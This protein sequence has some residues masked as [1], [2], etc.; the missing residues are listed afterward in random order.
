M[1][2]PP[3]T[4]PSLP[5]AVVQRLATHGWLDSIWPAVVLTALFLLA[6]VVMARTALRRR[7]PWWLG[8][9]I[10]AVIVTALLAGLAYVNAFAGYVPD[11]TAAARMA[12]FGGGRAPGLGTV[13]RYLLAAPAQRIPGCAV[14]VYLPPGYE[15]PRNTARYPVVYLLPG[16]PGRSVDW[17]SAGRIDTTMDLLIGQHSMPAAIVVAPD[18]NGGSPTRDTEGL[19]VYQ[20]PQ[21]QTYLAATV[22]AWVDRT[23]RTIPEPGA[24]IIGGMSAGGY[25]A[26]NLGLKYE[27]V[28]GG[29]IAQEPY[30][31]PGRSALPELNGSR[32]AFAA[33]SPSAYLATMRFTRREPTFIDVGGQV[34]SAAAQSL[35]QLLRRRGQPVEFRTEPGQYHTWTEARVGIAYGLV[36][37]AGELGW[38]GYPTR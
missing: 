33:E 20:G 17:F 6:G 11:S 34:N 8:G 21:V 36:W 10:A 30:G 28:F 27:G 29:I 13:H 7:G 4:S 38:S 5:A 23:F 22:P 16:F 32:A 14:W 24:R 2:G 3:G 35:A 15:R 18:M 12:G 9:S 19:N 26:L 1:V 31:D 37:T 25:V